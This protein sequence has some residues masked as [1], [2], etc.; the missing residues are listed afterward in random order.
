M[1]KANF[2]YNSF[3]LF[4]NQICF[5]FNFKHLQFFIKKR[6]VKQMFFFTLKEINLQ[7]NISGKTIF[8]IIFSQMVEK[9]SLF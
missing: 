3:L 9:V 4:Y 6:F 8:E 5:F 2:L 7:S 1:F